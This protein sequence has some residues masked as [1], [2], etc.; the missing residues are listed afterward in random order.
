MQSIPTLESD[1]GVCERAVGVD[2]CCQV[3]DVTA[4]GCSDETVMAVLE[5]LGFCLHIRL[6]LRLLIVQICH[7]S[8]CI[9][10]TQTHF[11]LYFFL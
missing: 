4:G 5:Q 9:Y 6:L 8:L 10:H 7:C 1:A 3:E 2:I 11:A